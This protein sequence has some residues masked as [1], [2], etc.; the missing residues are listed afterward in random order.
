MYRCVA[1]NVPHK[2]LFGNFYLQG[3]AQFGIS[4]SSYGEE[5]WW[6]EDG[7]DMG[8]WSHTAC[9]KSS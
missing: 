6:E 7:E 3:G 1:I 5:A 8:L 2:W 4:A 9:P